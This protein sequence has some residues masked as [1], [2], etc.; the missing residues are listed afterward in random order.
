MKAGE[1]DNIGWGAASE[2]VSPF[3]AVAFVQQGTCVSDIGDVRK[4][5]DGQI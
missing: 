4:P 5:P 3:P 1:R 2:G